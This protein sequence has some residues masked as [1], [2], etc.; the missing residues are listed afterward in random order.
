MA[1]SPGSA[2]S[3][4]SPDSPEADVLPQTA[5]AVL[6]LLAVSDKELSAVEIK[7]SADDSI[8]D[9]YWSPAVSHIRRELDRLL[10]QGLVEEREVQLGRLRRTLV[11]RP[12]AD[13]RAVL[14]SWVEN[15]AGNEQVTLKHPAVLR[16]FLGRSSPPQR[17]VETLD[18]QLE[19][20]RQRI[21]ELVNENAVAEREIPESPNDQYRRAVRRYLLRYYY[22]EQSNITQLRDKVRALVQEPAAA[23]PAPS[24]EVDHS[25]AGLTLLR[26]D[27][28]K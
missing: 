18:H 9:F 4:D 5:Y 11:Y 17:L 3:T 19:V 21:E 24:G 13:G 2:G 27:R 20:T 6:G 10:H 1:A 16:V 26:P 14:Q 28:V 23:N 8:D 25:A 12:T 22:D 7:A 15:G